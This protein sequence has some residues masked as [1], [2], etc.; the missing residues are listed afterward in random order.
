MDIRD[1]RFLCVRIRDST[2]RFKH[3]QES[4]GATFFFAIDP[5]TPILHIHESGTL[6]KYNILQD[7]ALHS[8]L[9]GRGSRKLTVFY[10]F[11]VARCYHS[12]CPS[13]FPSRSHHCDLDWIPSKTEHASPKG[14]DDVARPYRSNL[15]SIF[16]LQILLPPRFV[17][18]SFFA[19]SIV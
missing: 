12:T 18:E 8:R 17:I 2:R 3:V 6:T 7:V 4:S 16:A 14:G 9:I 13:M 5:L 10:A 11:Q 15:P 19:M 1:G